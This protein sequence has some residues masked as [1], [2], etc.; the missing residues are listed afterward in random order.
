[1]YFEYFRTG[2]QPK[3]PNAS[4]Q[5]A[6]GCLDHARVEVEGSDVRSVEAVEE[7]VDADT[8]TT[9]DLEHVLSGE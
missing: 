1:M 7:H 4:V 5:A 6:A 3:K 2:V 8:A 9:P